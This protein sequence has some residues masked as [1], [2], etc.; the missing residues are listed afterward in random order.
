MTTFDLR[1]ALRGLRRRPG[2]P[3]L[4]VAILALGLGGFLA[5]WSA[6]DAVLWR[7]L[8]YPQPERLV[9][10][11]GSGNG[12]R[13]NNANPLDARDWQAQARHSFSDLAVFNSNQDTVSGLG[14]APPDFL[15]VAR[16]SSN[17]FHTLGVEPALGRFF[18]NREETLGEHRVAV[19]SWEQWQG[20]FGGGDVLGKQI[21]V[22]GKPYV[23]VG[24]AP[25]GFV[26]PIPDLMRPAALYRPL[27]FDPEKVGR[28]GHWVNVIGRLKP[29]V[30]V[31]AAQAEIDAIDRHLHQL[32][33]DSADWNAFVEPLHQA[34]AGS[35]RQALTL[36]VAATAL[37]LLLACGN[38]AALLLARATGRVGELAVRG[39]LGASRGAL[40]RQLLAEMLLLGLFAGAAGVLVGRALLR[41][42]EALAAG[43]VPLLERASI[44]G[45]ALLVGLVAT[46]LTVA[47]AGAAPTLHGLRAATAP[48]EGRRVTASRERRRVERALVTAQL[49]LCLT[50]LV[51]AALL[52]RSLERLYR[53]DPGFRTDH[54]L[55]FGVYL[56]GDRY[57]D[58][59]ASRT[60]FERLE[61]RLAQ[62][63]GVEAVG[64]V[65]NLP[66]GGGYSCSSIVAEG[67]ASLDPKSEP[68]VEER[69][70][71]PGYF[72]AIGLHLLDGRTFAAGDD[73]R[74]PVVVVSESFAAHHWPCPPEETG[75]RSA[76]GR[77]VKWG[78]DASSE[79]P[80]RT[81]VGVV[82]DVRHFGFDAPIKPEIYMP[83]AQ[84][85]YSGLDV[86]VRSTVPPEKLLPTL[87]RAVA[88]LDPQIPLARPR[89]MDELLAQSTAA[90]R[91]R[92]STL[93]GFAALA[94]VLAIA[95]LYG[96]LAHAVGMRRRELSVRMAVGAGKRQIVGLVM[97]EGAALTA[98]G[99]LVGGAGALLAARAL[100]QLLFGVQPL[101]PASFAVAAALLA[102]VALLAAWVPARRA[103]AVDPVRALRE[104]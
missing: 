101:D 90:R 18:T 16:V 79:D 95:G 34:I 41:G 81:V 60:Y 5:L 76:L 97:G 26:H 44:D 27:A 83:E 59:A 17:F 7:P 23:I 69:V 96:S 53:V 38:V 86:V 94:L 8:G 66:L 82:R 89:A 77:R 2:V 100:R 51:G 85:A 99:L 32:Y 12:E 52:A 55:T 62:V 57:A 30:S 91:L 31:A 40:V 84:Q 64:G 42:L 61:T 47:I 13:R 9:R 73:A 37:L 68:C 92:T 19:L 36:L 21:A 4:V 25:R 20:R 22:D 15:P 46:L 49:A 75:C 63:P 10:V 35:S 103:A 45:R 104:E 87:R 72:R 80:W 29:G 78:L 56:Y 74:A 3:L 98:V 39:A 58:E 6:A 67:G 50:L 33:P 43:Q 70:A 48:T 65:S 24:V 102:A 88:E 1:Q 28:G 93:G 11:W 14:D 71:T 54:A